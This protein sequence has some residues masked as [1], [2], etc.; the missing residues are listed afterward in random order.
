[1]VEQQYNQNDLSSQNKMPFLK[2]P[3][4]STAEALFTN[5]PQLSTGTIYKK[6]HFCRGRYWT[7]ECRTCPTIEKQ[8]EVI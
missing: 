6:C 5:E 8:K 7:A 1:M 3:R 2:S 4:K